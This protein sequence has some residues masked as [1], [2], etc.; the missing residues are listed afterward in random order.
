MH[1]VCMS[2]YM[3]VALNT[4][5]CMCMP[6]AHARTYTPLDHWMHPTITSTG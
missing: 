6:Q 3:S 4:Y 5:V 1:D 2:A